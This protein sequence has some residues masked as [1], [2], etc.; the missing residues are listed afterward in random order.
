[1]MKGKEGENDVM[2]E[3]KRREEG[4]RKR[5]RRDGQEAKRGGRK[6]VKDV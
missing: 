6:L 2:W 3:G 1:M 5:K 4:Y